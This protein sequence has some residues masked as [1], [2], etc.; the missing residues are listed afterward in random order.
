MYSMISFSVA[1]L[2]SGA[3]IGGAAVTLPLLYF[4][5]SRKKEELLKQLGS[6]LLELGGSEED[7]FLEAEVDG[8]IDRKLDD[9]VSIF[10]RQ[11]PV[12]SLF[13]TGG[14]L[15]KLKAS[16]QAELAKMMPEMKQKLLF[17]IKQRLK[18]EGMD[19]G[20]IDRYC[21]LY[22]GIGAAIG[23]GLGLVLA[24]VQF[25]ILYASG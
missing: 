1:A 4:R 18:L 12:A 16:A 22:G 3:L 10:K 11:I 17:K 6:S 5:F 20:L 8:L 14:L 25:A 21:W 24:W 19:W 9:L 2:I 15:L 23:A 13:L 7:D